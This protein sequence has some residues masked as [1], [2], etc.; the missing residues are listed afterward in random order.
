[1]KAGPSQTVQGLLDAE[2]GIEDPLPDEAGDDQRHGE[3]I[4]K[5]GAQK[6]F[7]PDSLVHEYGEQIAE[8]HIA[9]DRQQ[10]EEPDVV[11]GDHPAI[12]GPQATILVEADKIA[13]RKEPG[14]GERP[15]ERESD[16]DD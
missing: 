3:G 5:D 15:I 1:M 13:V 14:T 8:H 4:E 10:A 9:A 16:T 12:A 6:V 7:L 11:D 2:I